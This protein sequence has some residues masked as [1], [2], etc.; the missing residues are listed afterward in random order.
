VA[1]TPIAASDGRSPAVTPPVQSTATVL[2]NTDDMPK[3]MPAP[4]ASSTL[5]TA[6]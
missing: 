6:G 3:A 1:K 4:T 5:R 2:V